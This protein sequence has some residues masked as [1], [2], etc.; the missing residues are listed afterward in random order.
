LLADGRT[1]IGGVIRLLA[2]VLPAFAGDWIEAY[3]DNPFYFLLLAGVIAL[4]F[5]FGTRM[6]RTLRDDA[7]LVWRQALTGPVPEPPTSVIQTFRNS[8]R[9]Q[10]SVQV[11]KWYFLP[12]WVVTPV[13]VVAFLW[14]ALGAFTQ[15]TLPF[16][17]NGTLLCQPSR[18]PLAAIDRVSKDFMTRNV[19]SESFGLVQESKHYVVTF[20]VGQAWYDGSLPASPEGISSSQFPW[21]LGYLAGPLKRVINAHYLQPLLEIRPIPESGRGDGNIQIYPLSVQQVGDSG[22]L[23]RADFTAARKG[24]LFLFVNDAMVPLTDPRWGDYGYRFFYQASG[25]PPGNRGSA[26]VTVESADAMASAM[27]TAPGGSICEQVSRRNA[28]QPKR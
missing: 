16:L 17:E 1:W 27:S 20:D 14:I 28:E 10:R 5:A 24:E 4:L 9:Y 13:M 7:R 11:F 26:C 18:T 23:F 12:D 22:T 21:G 6:E 3:A 2:L 25:T 19:C 15:T 8:R